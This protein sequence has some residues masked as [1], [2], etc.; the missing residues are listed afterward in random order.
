MRIKE[1]KKNLSEYADISMRF[2]EVRLDHRMTQKE[3][4]EMV[5]LTAASIGA[6][7]A[8]LYTPNFKVLRILRQKLN[9]HYDYLI[10]GIQNGKDH[11]RENVEL[12]KENERLKKIIDKLTQ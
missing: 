1:G 5:G 9:V 11:T 6:I 4:G 12:R 3:F 8:G 10:D 7:E 2:R